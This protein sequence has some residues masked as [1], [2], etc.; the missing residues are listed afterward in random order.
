MIIGKKLI[1][2][3]YNENLD[4]L[5]HQVKIENHEKACHYT[6]VD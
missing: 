6:K 5:C 3:R 1:T 4:I 2:I